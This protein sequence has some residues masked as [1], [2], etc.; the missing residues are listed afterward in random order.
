[1]IRNRLWLAPLWVQGL[2][3][4]AMFTLFI[5][6]MVVELYPMFVL[7]AGW[8]LTALAVIT[9]CV[10]TT[11]AVLLLQRPARQRGLDALGAG[12]RQ[13]RLTALEAL[14]TGQLPTDPD[15]LAGAIRYADFAAA[16]RR[17]A[18]RTQRALQWLVPVAAISYGLVELFLLP[19]RFGVLLIGVGLWWILLSVLR[20]RRRRRTSR[21]LETLRAAANP[22]LVSVTEDGA[23]AALPPIRFRLAF[24]AVVIPV[25]A[26]MML[27]YVVTRADPDCY[28][29]AGAADLI[30]DHWQLADPQNMT[31]G[32]PDLAAYRNWAQELHGY[33]DRVTD[34]RLAPRLH[35]ISDLADRAVT[36]F[37]ESRDAMFKQPPPGYDLTTQEKAFNA[38]MGQLADEDNAVFATCFPRH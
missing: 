9:L 35:R 25:V 31:R 5:G 3:R 21:N 15:T 23:V 20:A 24:V 6:A 29:V 33:A 16:Y 30:H 8:P 19:A 11:G 12:T 32:Q 26:F 17:K 18:S 7:R 22:D 28:Y 38:T 4:A 10:I 1:M 37:T 14:R 2:I 34:P 27:V 13:Q 36:L